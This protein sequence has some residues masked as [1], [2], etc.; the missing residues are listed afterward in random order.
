MGQLYSY[1]VDAI[2]PAPGDVLTF[3]LPT[4]PAGMT[5]N[6]STGLIQWT[7]TVAQVGNNPVTVRVAN[8]GGLFVTQ[9]FIVTVTQPATV[10][11][12]PRAL[13]GASPR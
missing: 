8:Q 1:D 2:A 7:P 11:V 13:I 12:G 5:I 10:V 4:A 3:T 6:A 9:S